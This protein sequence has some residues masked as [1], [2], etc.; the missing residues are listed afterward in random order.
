MTNN[1]TNNDTCIE[2]L[3]LEYNF[4]PLYRRLR[5][6]SYKINLVARAMLW[7]MYEEAFENK[8]V[9]VDLKDHDLSI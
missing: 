2:A 3:S 1:V 9:A 8:L 4:N 7:G 6:S 5:Y